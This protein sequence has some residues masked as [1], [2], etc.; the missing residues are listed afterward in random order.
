VD[1]TTLE[2]LPL[3][4]S[5]SPSRRL[6]LAQ[7]L[8]FGTVGAAGFIVDTATVYGLRYSLGLYG[9]GLVAYVLAASCN[10]IL[11]RLW[12]F[13][14]TGSGSAHRQWAMFM[15]T[16]LAGFV[17]NQSSPQPPALPLECS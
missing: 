15:A 11:N 5:I 7:F 4:R 13:R 16:N 10:W 6:L 3:W 12:T 17:L 8:R 14:G 9:A 2:R 1:P